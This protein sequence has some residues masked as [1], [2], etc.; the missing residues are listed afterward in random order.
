M[1]IVK[2]ILYL[3]LILF[4]SAFSQVVKDKLIDVNT[5]LNINSD[6]NDQLIANPDLY[7]LDS[8]ISPMEYILGPGDQ[9]VL[10]IFTVES[11]T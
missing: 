8:Q 6:E 5:G 2:Y 1:N 7:I 3:I 9:L 11:K 4:T 10:N